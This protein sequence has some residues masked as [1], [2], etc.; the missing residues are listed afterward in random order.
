MSSNQSNFD[1]T[2]KSQAGFIW[3]LIESVIGFAHIFSFSAQ[4]Y[5]N[6][7]IW[8]GGNHFNLYGFCLKCI[9]SALLGVS[10]IGNV[11]QEFQFADF[12]KGV[13]WTGLILTLFTAWM[14]NRM[15]DT[16]S[17]IH[18]KQTYAE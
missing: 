9:A 13:R 6:D 12:E 17:G 14:L 1:T 4:V 8:P 7:P 2:W 15:A 18:S 11:P 5:K 16:K 3:S 10:L